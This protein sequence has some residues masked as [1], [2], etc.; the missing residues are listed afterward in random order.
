MSRL[1]LGIDIGGTKIIVGL[2]SETGQVIDEIA[3]APTPARDGPAAILAQVAAMARIA[4]SGQS[5]VSGIGVGSAGVFDSQG[6]VTSSTD[7][8]YGWAGTPVSSQL[9]EL[10]GYRVVTV[11]DV[12][13]AAIG[14]GTVGAA[15]LA[16]NAIIVTVG[17][18]VGGALI[19]NSRTYSGLSGVAGSV[20]HVSLS[21]EPQLRCSCGQLGHA[22]PY[23]SGPGM[24]R[25]HLKRFAEDLSLREIAARA[26]KGDTHAIETLHRGA[27]A[28]GE[29]LAS[30]AN[31]VDPDLIVIGGGVSS[32]GKY[33]LDI[34]RVAYRAR[35][36][37]GPSSTPIVAAQLGPPATLIGAGLL[38]L[39]TFSSQPSHPTSLGESPR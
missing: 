15:V 37:A 17:T 6:V 34:V 31:I 25:D 16:T 26:A 28:L 24:E 20:G 13:A 4:L 23:A 7:I 2:V 14:E 11:N 10:C 5:D 22:E 29:V 36:M 21:R 35:V 38:A 12:H 9:A 18:G 33:Y 19:L 32:I 39:A 3:T 8:L 1:A 30:T 27:T